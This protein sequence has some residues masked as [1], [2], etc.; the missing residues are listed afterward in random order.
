MCLLPSSKGRNQDTKQ[1]SVPSAL[2]PLRTSSDQPMAPLALRISPEP[3]QD[4]REAQ[5][6]RATPSD[7]PMP[8]FPSPSP[9]ANEKAARG[10][11]DDDLYLPD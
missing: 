2:T 10:K 8:F 9:H 7:Q 11:D 1:A 5:E 6:R 4:T 3:V